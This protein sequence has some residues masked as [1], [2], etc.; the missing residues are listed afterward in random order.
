MKLIAWLWNPWDQYKNNRHNAGFLML[1]K[2]IDS[3]FNCTLKYDSKVQAEVWE[4]LYDW[5]KIIFVKPMSF[6]NRS[7]SAISSIANFYKIEPEN[8]LVIHDEIDLQNAIIKLKFG[9]SHAGHNWLKDIFARLWTDKL[10]R[11][12]IGVDRPATKEQVVDYVL[13]NFKKD[14]INNIEDK[15]PEIIWYVKNF[16]EK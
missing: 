1:Q 2:I 14:E 4:I 13:E 9:W 10:W 7:G 3:E 12:R 5:E 16:L 6:M 11:I 15:L 8:I